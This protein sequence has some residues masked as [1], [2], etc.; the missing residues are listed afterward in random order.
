MPPAAPEPQPCGRRLMYE[1]LNDRMIT[2][3]RRISGAN[4][5]ID[6]AGGGR[7]VPALQ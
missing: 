1:Q 3:K 4:A 5:P 6:V 2:K 7:G